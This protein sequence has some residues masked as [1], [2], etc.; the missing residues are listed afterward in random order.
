MKTH[1][2]TEFELEDYQAYRD[3]LTNEEI[4]NRLEYIGRGYIGDYNFTGTESD[5]ELYK[6]H[7]ALNA[8]MKIVEEAAKNS[9]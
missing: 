9:P 6:M 1:T 2:V 3:N 8:A 4:I 5:F 7:T